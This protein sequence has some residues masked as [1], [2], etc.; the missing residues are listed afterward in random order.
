MALMAK[1]RLKFK[2]EMRRDIPYMEKTFP[3]SAAIPGSVILEMEA[4]A[5]E[6]GI[7]RSAF[8]VRAVEAQ[9]A[10]RRAAKAA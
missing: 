3:I 10:S 4:A 6:L 5:Q 8:I 9:L 1:R 2:V 7:G